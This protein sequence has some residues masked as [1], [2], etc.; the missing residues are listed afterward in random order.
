ML[1]YCCVAVLTPEALLKDSVDKAII[2]LLY[3][4]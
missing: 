2:I 1:A 3:V 4:Q